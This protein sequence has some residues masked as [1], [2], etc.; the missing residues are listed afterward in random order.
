MSCTGRELGPL[1]LETQYYMVHEHKIN[2]KF[3]MRFAVKNSLDL[4]DRAWPGG[5]SIGLSLYPVRFFF[6]VQ[7]FRKCFENHLDLASWLIIVRLH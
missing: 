1:I 5:R 3:V 7:E 2:I 4:S 6:L